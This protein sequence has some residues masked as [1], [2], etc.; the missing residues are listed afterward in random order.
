MWMAHGFIKL[1]D[2][3]QCLEDVGHEYY[4]DLLWRSFFQE[5]EEDEFGNI[6]KFKIHDLMHDIAI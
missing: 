1:Y 4:M 3:K 5:V 2:E 6:S